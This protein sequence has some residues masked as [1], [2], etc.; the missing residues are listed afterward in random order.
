MTYGRYKGPA[1]PWDGTLYGFIEPKPDKEVLKTSVFFIVS[2]MLKERVMLPNFG[3]NLMGIVFEAGD[4]I[5]ANAVRDTIVSAI[6]EWDPR[7][8][9]VD[10]IVEIDDAQNQLNC[11]LLFKDARDP[12]TAELTNFEF[13]IQPSGT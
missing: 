1:L 2:T 12:I 4:A 5:S 13:R 11:R 6:Q 8:I 9:V 10:C 3:T 7:V